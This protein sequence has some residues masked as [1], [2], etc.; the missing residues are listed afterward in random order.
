MV[1]GLPLSLAQT[2]AVAVLADH[3]YDYLPGS[4]RWAGTYTFGS[5]AV[6]NGVGDFWLGGSKRPALTQLLEATLGNRTS[7]FCPLIESI[8]REGLKY[9]LRS[10]APVTKADLLELNRLIALVGFKIPSLWD[11]TFAASLPDRE[12]K[13]SAEPTD[14]DAS[15]NVEA[16]ERQLRAKRSAVLGGLRDR[17]LELH[18]WSDRQAAGR[19]FEHLLRAIF[20]EFD[21]RPRGSFVV[22]GEQIDGSIALDG[23][24]Y[25]VEAKWESGPV[26]VAPLLIFREKVLGKS[27]VTRGIFVSVNGYDTGARLSITTGKQPN[28]LMLDGM[29]LF[30]VLNGQRDLVSLLRALLRELADTGRPFVPLPEVPD[31]E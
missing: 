6:E 23:S 4:S 25:L 17:F 30:A 7:A 16:T 10:G 27:S 14:S 8:V 18:G 21:L 22:P 5:A 13:R 2:Q 9:R 29:H 31:D 26:G 24:F 3:L 19:E 20:D 1:T 11:P 15:F 12:T 28:F